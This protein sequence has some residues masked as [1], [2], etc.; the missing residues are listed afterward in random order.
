MEGTVRRLERPWCT[1]W[2]SPPFREALVYGVGLYW[3]F[4]YIPGWWDGRDRG[5]VSVQ[6]G[7]LIGLYWD[8]PYVPGWW[9]KRD[10]GN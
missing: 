10:S 6:C 8:L 9:D 4:L 7:T 2:D 1:V 5:S 3:D